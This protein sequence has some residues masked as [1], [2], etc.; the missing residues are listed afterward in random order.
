MSVVVPGA[1]VWHSGHSFERVAL[2][3]EPA[4][5]GRGWI[6][7]APESEAAPQPANLT[8]F[9]SDKTGRATFAL[10]GR[11]VVHESEVIGYSGPDN[12]VHLLGST[13]LLQT[14]VSAPEDASQLLDMPATG[15][16]V[17]GGGEA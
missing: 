3:D 14:E 8:L 2:E 17:Q 13:S 15:D 16:L 7:R 4:N 5:D 10:W 6:H 1:R 11:V 9:E 12:V